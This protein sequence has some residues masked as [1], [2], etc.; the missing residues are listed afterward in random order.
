MVK[1]TLYNC[2]NLQNLKNKMK[3]RKTG[4][5][6]QNDEVVKSYNKRDQWLN[7]HNNK[8]GVNYKNIT[9]I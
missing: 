2:K 1:E 4:T 9:E 7:R 8:H 3:L 6:Q 5:K